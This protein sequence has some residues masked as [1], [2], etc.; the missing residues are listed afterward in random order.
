MPQPRDR[1]L[2]VAGV[3]TMIIAHSVC[4]PRYFNGQL[5]VESGGKLANGSYSEVAQGSKRRLALHC[6]WLAFVSFLCGRD[7]AEYNS[8]KHRSSI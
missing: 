7:V 8:C 3:Q 2:G 1:R 5:S 6:L 4:P